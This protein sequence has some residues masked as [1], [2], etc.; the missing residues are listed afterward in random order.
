[1]S[2]NS[3]AFY[4]LLLLS[5]NH[6]YQR[7]IYTGKQEVK[8]ESRKMRHN[9]NLGTAMVWKNIFHFTVLRWG[10][11]AFLI[12]TNISSASDLY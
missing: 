6:I 8:M 2:A 9:F 5:T 4:D 1:M 3:T 12:V 11:N 10:V 7:M